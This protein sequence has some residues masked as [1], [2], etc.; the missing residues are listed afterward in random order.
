MGQPAAVMGDRVTGT[1]A[2]HLMP[3]ASGTQPAGPL[4]FSAPLLEGL[5]TT[6]LIG[7]KAAVVVG[8][9]GMNTPPH[10]ST[11]VDPSGAAPPMQRAT[12]T[13]GSA[14]VT[15]EGK[16]AAYSGSTATICTGLPLGTVMGTAATVMIGA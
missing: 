9:G 14:T 3:S 12:V 15:F 7:G 11:L 16:P 4:P 2:V 10:P 1:C 8:S 13:M 6:V 5:A